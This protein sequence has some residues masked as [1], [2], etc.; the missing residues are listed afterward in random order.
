MSQILIIKLIVTIMVVATFIY[1]LINFSQSK[2]LLSFPK[3][4]QTMIT[5]FVA[6]FL[7]TFGIGSFASIF[8]F[9]NAFGLME[10]NKRYNGSIVVQATLPTLLQS[11]LFLQLVKIDSLTLITACIMIAIGGV[12]SGYF[13][14]YVTRNAIYNVMLVTFILT[15][16]ILLLNSMHMLAVGGDL[17]SVRGTK[18]IVLGIVM[19]MAGCLPAFGVGY[20]SI[21][22]VIIFLLGLSPAV[23][24]PIMTTASAV[25]MPMT[26]VPMIKNRQYYSWSTLLMAIPGCLAVLIAAPII[27]K[28]DASYLKWVLLVVIFYNIWTLVK[29]KR[30]LISNK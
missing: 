17:I 30:S 27:S 14:K 24:Y 1:F 23:A 9:R 3:K 21:V 11:V 8:A 18:L 28:V 2:E 26:A 5:G 6:T 12:V 4:L 19:F 13:V 7:D 25:Q 10:D 16:I 15:V 20:Y 29:A 22:L